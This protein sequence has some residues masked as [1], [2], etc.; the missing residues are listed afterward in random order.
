MLCL[1]FL[2]QARKAKGVAPTVQDR[3]YDLVGATHAVYHASYVMLPITF[4]KS[5][6]PTIQW[7]DKWRLEDFK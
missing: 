2:H 1:C 3:R 6:K 5:G 4:D 7:R